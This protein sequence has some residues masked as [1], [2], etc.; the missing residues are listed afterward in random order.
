[1]EGKNV[2]ESFDKIARQLLK[3]ALSNVDATV[4]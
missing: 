2:E 3:N 1:M 4:L